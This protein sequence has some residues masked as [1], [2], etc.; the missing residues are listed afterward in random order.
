MK[1]EKQLFQLIVMAALMLIGL[2]CSL[3]LSELFIQVHGSGGRAIKSFC[4]VSEGF[5]CVTV[6]NS[7]W[8]VVLRVPTAFWGVEFY[9]A[10]LAYA[11]LSFFSLWPLRKWQSI[12]F[13][14]NAL[15]LP[16]C[17]FLEFVCVA[18]IK[19]ICIVCVAVHTINLV[20]VLFLGILHRRRFKEFALEGPLEILRFFAPKSMAR[21]LIIA[22]VLA[23]ASQIIWMPFLLFS[24][25]P[26]NARW[27]GMPV[28]GFSI[29]RTDAPIQIDEFTDFQCPFC[30]KAHH[31][32]MELLVEYPD[33]IHLTHR[34]YPLDVQCNPYLKKPFHPDAC[35]ASLYARCAAQQD[36]F[37]PMEELLFGNRFKL[38]KSDLGKHAEQIGCDMNQFHQCLEDPETMRALLEDIHEA[39]RR[40]IDGTPTFY[41]NGK[42]IVGV[43][44]PEQWREIIQGLLAAQPK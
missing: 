19:S 9:L 43:K 5:N 30:G 28:S 25:T 13:A 16:F 21:Y 24:P 26:A 42:P 33:K 31:V 35:K 8:A 27:Q 32:I 40:G 2:V 18:Y 23:G 29:G 39:K 1:Q 36:L 3:Y 11:L 37:R 41:V 38:Q 20:S 7:K 12:L 15:S 4:A 17:I 14:A 44:S 34:D 6:A 10:L 22:I